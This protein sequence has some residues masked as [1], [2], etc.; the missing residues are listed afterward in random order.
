VPIIKS[1]FDFG[2]IENLSTAAALVIT[3]VYDRAKRLCGSV[4][5]A[6]NLEDWGDDAFKVFYEIGFFELIGHV[7][8][9]HPSVRYHDIDDGRYRLMQIMSGQNANELEDV[10]DGI[11]GLLEYLGHG[12]ASLG[13]LSVEINGALGEAMIN[14][15][16]H[17]YP[18]E[19]KA[20]TFQRSVGRWWIT[21]R[22]DRDSNTLTI[23]VYDQGATIPG[24]LPR[25]VW[26]KELIDYIKRTI[27]YADAPNVNLD[28]EYIAYSM[29]RGKTQTLEPGRGEGLPQMQELIDFCG[30]GWLR[31]FSRS[32]AYSYDSAG[33]VTKLKLPIPIEGT[34]VEWELKL[35]SVT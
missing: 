10:A 23:V 5:P 20:K 28:H 34:L 14:V 7:H 3:S 8:G 15:A 11:S 6:I 4:P 2:T 17:A 33:G 26:F 13:D 30:S 18:P 19:Y 22:A 32:G 29:R 12:N 35:P 31:I 24:T 9:A 21:G 1:Y 25:R 27:V 16:R